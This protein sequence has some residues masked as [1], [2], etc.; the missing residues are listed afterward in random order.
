MMAGSQQSAR[1]EFKNPQVAKIIGD[2]A[3]TLILFAGGLDTNR[4]GL[5]ESAVI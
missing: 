1:I 5:V 3:L 4:L 2:F